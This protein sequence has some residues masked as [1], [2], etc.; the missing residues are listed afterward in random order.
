V[1]PEDVVGGAIDRHGV[2]DG[3]RASGCDAAVRVDAW[4]KATLLNTLVVEAAGSPREVN[5]SAIGSR[6][7]AQRPADIELASRCSA[8]HYR[9]PHGAAVCPNYS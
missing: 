2:L 3:A 6:K 8:P 7:V 9:N 1:R 4:T 5:S